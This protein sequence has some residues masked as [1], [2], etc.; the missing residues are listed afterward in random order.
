MEM[1]DEIYTSIYM[2]IVAVLNS[3]YEAKNMILEKKEMLRRVRKRGIY[4]HNVVKVVKE[5]QVKPGDKRKDW[6]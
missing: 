5:T 6:R 3:R 2:C 1:V 4:S